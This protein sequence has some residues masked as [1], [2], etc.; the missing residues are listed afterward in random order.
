MFDKIVL[1]VVAVVLAATF[2]FPAIAQVYD[3][4]FGD[5]GTAGVVTDARVS[6]ED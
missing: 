5:G 4:L 3:E 1:G 6:R 2:F